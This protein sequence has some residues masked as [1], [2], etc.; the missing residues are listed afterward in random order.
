MSLSQHPVWLA[1]ALKSFVPS[2]C[3][4]LSPEDVTPTGSYPMAAGGFADIWEATY[5]RRKVA[6]KCYRY[7]STSNVAHIIE[8]RCDFEQLPAEH[9]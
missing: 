7:H 6:L 5:E 4:F 1:R 2:T 3:R 8:V 9:G